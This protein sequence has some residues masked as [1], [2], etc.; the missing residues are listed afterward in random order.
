M[1]HS[2]GFS[3]VDNRARITLACFLAYFVMSGM[4]SPIGI[5]LPPLAE[6]LALPVEM[7]A[8][9]FSWLTVGI[10]VGSALALG[11]F[12]VLSV[13]AWFIVLFLAIVVIGRAHV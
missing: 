12:D 2:T 10:L 3:L 11:A 7:V 1:S 9:L 5:V 13:R 8:P 6:H 4:L